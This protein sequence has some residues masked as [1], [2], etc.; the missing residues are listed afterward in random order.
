LTYASGATPLV[1][2]SKAD[3]CDDVPVRLAEVAG[4]ASGVMVVAA[5]LLD[6]VPAEVRAALA[7]GRTAVLLGSSGVGKSTLINRLLHGEVQRTRAVRAKD[8]R[9][10]HTTTHR[11]LF[12]VSGGGLVIDSPGLREIQ[13]WHGEEGVDAAF[14]DVERLATRCHFRDCHHDDEPGCAVCAAVAAG[15]LSSDRLASWH[16]L[17]AELAAAAAKEDPFAR[18]SARRRS[19]RGAG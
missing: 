15:E 17:H 9:G 13:L 11:Q 3:L 1:V 18:R 8:H 4:V 6:E 19:A 2:L 12:K 7:P 14:D 16:K 5:R 10:K